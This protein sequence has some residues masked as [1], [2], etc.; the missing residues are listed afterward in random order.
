MRFWLSSF[1]LVLE[2]QSLA[3][4]NIPFDE[5][6]TE[7]KKNQEFATSEKEFGSMAT[8]SG[9]SERPSGGASR[10]AGKKAGPLLSHPGKTEQTMHSSPSCGVMVLLC[11]QLKHVRYQVKVNEKYWFCW[12]VALCGKSQCRGSASFFDIQIWENPLFSLP[13]PGEAP[14]GGVQIPPANMGR[15]G[16]TTPTS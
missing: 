16:R 12:G 2:G 7:N 10:K 5:G 13:T 1:D 9:I 14:E 6:P 3:K 8:Q 4:K 11:L 15:G